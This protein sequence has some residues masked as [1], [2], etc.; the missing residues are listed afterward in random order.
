MK[1]LLTV[2]ITFC[3]S[4]SLAACTKKNPVY[5]IDDGITLELKDVLKAKNENQNTIYYYYLFSITNDRDEDYLLDK[6]K[7]SL[8]DDGKKIKSY[9][10]EKYVMPTKLLTAKSTGYVCGHI[11][12]ANNNQKDVGLYFDNTKTF[13]SFKNVKIH[14]ASSSDV[15]TTQKGMKQTLF[16]DS[17][18]SIG[19]D[20]SQANVSFE[21][22]NTVLSNFGI[23]YENK[24]D[25]TIVVPYIEPKA[26]LNGLL[27]TDYADKG[28]F[29]T[30]D[31][32][33]IKTLDVK[34]NKKVPE[35]KQIDGEASGFA[36]I[37][38]NPGQSLT[39]ATAMTFHNSFIC[40]QNSDETPIQVKLVN[41][42]MGINATVYVSREAKT[43]EIEQNQ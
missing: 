12:F 11:G 28:D 42:G 16:E 35:T 17:T 24:T 36:L 40:Y 41:P 1:K 14:Q 43:Q 21:F 38:L 3:L 4:L 20:Y 9:I 15:R 18:I 8:R 37:Y 2:F 31:I 13:M 34:K 25:E 6:F 33:K 5:T 26:T 32:E 22:G 27:T 7:F 39:V 23:V 30:M 10:S 29:Q 19:F